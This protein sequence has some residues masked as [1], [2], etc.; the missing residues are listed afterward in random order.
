[1]TKNQRI[2]LGLMILNIGIALIFPKFSVAD[3]FNLGGAIIGFILFV[4]KD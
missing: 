1:M 4:K 3:L 2:G